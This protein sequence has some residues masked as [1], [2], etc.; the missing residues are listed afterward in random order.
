MEKILRNR[1]RCKKCDDIIESKFTHD[2]K[3]CKCGA[4]AIDGGLEYQRISFKY[5]QD[6][7]DF[8]LS[9]YEPKETDL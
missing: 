2:M 1:V 5:S 4:I 8:S 7:F 6:D 3:W 9:E